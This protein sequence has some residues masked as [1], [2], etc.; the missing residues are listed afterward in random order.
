MTKIPSENSKTRLSSLLSKNQRIKLSENLIDKNMKLIQNHD[1]ILSLTPDDL[2]EDYKKNFDCESIKQIGK[3]IGERMYN[4]ISFAISKGYDKVI[5]IGSDIYDFDEKIFEDA[6]EKLD[7]AD[8]VFSPTEDGGYSLIGMK[9]SHKSI[10]EN[11]KYSNSHVENDLENS[12]I[13]NNLTYFKLRQ[14]HDIDTDIDLI[15]YISKSKNVTLIGKGEYNSNYL[16]DND[17]LIRI[18]RGSQMHLDNQIQYEYN[19]LKFLEKSTATP[20]VY[21]LK[22]DELSDI[23][24]LTEEYLLG[25]DLDYSKDLDTAAY[26]LSKVHSLDVTNADF[27]K[28]DN[29]FEMMYSE[30]TEM[31]SHYK[32]WSKKSIATEQK[33]SYMLDYIKN[34]GL[35]SDLENPCMINTELNNKNFIIGEKSYIIDWE[36]PIIGEREQDLAHFLAPTTTFWKT[37]VIFDKKIMDKFLDEYDKNS[38]VKVNRTKFSKYLVFTCLRGITWCS[39]AYVQYVEEKK[40]GFTFEKIKSYLTD[41]FL[42]MIMEFIK[43]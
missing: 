7:D 31:F 23:T 6:F 28:A 8:V 18:A 27:I 11:K 9:S 3:D 10:F 19:A 20:K 41:E 32:N 26:L 29:P 37:D 38:N 34:L 24:Y 14:T 36:K 33:I 35:D 17:Y 43:K 15:K 1:V 21:D 13:E 5:L 30:F 42:D 40:N 16:I 39:M 25:R 12:L 2:F 4:S 22:F